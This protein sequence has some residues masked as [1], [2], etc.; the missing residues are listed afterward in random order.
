[1]PSILTNDLPPW[2]QSW[3]D[4]GALIN[5]DAPGFGTS[6]VRDGAQVGRGHPPISIR[7]NTHCTKEGP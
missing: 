3:L 5:V 2:W 1:M 7:A 4:C 6:V